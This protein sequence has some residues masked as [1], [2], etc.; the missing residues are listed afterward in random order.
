MSELATVHASWILWLNTLL[1]EVGIPVPVTPTALVL[2][3][4]A[5]HDVGDFT[6]LVV[7]IIAGILA[8]NSVWFAAGRRYGNGVLKFL[9]RFSLTAD[10]CV[11]RTENTFGRWGAASLVIGRFIPGVSLIAAPLS[12]AVGM[13]WAKFV[14]LTT[15]GGALYG[16][17][18]VGA[19]VLFRNQ[20][21]VVMRAL[22]ALGWQ[23]L[24]VVLVA[25]ALYIAW[26]WWRRMVARAPDLAR[27]SAYELQKLIAD[28]ERPL[29]VD[30]RGKTTQQIDPRHIPEAINVSLDAIEH[31]SGDLPRDRKI[32]L[33]CACPNEATAAKAA[34]VLLGRGYAWVR[35]LTGGLDAWNAALEQAPAPSPLAARVQLSSPPSL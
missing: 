32:V 3:A 25:V 14:A 22:E 2:G 34:S 24:G 10:T 8:G 1:H 11:S 7:A 16:V 18:V 23:A 17:V 30:L 15:M 28:G 20:I 6:L 33:Y 4:H 12:G 29:I 26:R 21:S 5:V 19:G 31:N 27:I 9:C 13:S 35:P